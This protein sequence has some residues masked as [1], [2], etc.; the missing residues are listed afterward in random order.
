M[1]PELH[2][3][4]TKAIELAARRRGF[5][6]FME[7]GLGKT[8]TTLHEFNELTKLREAQR[9]VVVCP[10]SFKRGWVADAQ[11][12][13]FD[14]DMYVWEAGAEREC[15]RWFK[16]GFKKPAVLIVNYESIRTEK[17]QEVIR[18][19]I[20]GKLCYLA[21]DESIRLKNNKSLQTKAILGLA[22][23]FEYVRV[24]S[25]KPQTQ[26]P[27][28]LWGQLRAIG[29]IN[30]MSFYAFRTMFCK[31]GGWMN[32][33]VV[34]VQNE[35]HL[36]RLMGD[37]VF[38]ATKHEYAA[39]LPEKTYTIRRYDPNKEVWS[40]YTSMEEEFVTYIN[41][42]EVSVEMAM[43]KYEK[44]AQIQAG[45]ILDTETGALHEIVDPEVNTRIIA[46]QEVM[47][48]VSG[49]VCVV[50]THRH[51]RLLLQQALAAYSPAVIAGG[52]SGD[53]VEAEKA[54]FNN[55]PDC[56]V[57]LL[58]QRSAKYGHTLLGGDNAQDSCSTMVFFEN[59]Y[60]LD[61][62]SQIEDRIHRHG[63]KY[64]CTYID[65]AGT[66]LDFKVVE[67]LQ[68]KESIFQS[69]FRQLRS[70]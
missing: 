27:H 58:Q 54:R 20:D 15:R 47:E 1:L 13:G 48:E 19:F 70:K 22:P 28:D 3:A 14:F 65:L 16:D 42:T 66:E 61:D 59:S 33:Q 51:S 36:G 40:H 23:L 38:Y 68:H 25:G 31:M 64:P 18:S 26:G 30:G 2:I 39:E 11:K 37:S 50:Y 10:N 45:F 43:T 67:A 52:M 56:R 17:V 49:K 34:G 53:D 35:Q 4:Q 21:I 60:S 63:Q 55:D 57:I 12:W 5:A 44:M 69:V 29:L 32:K 7:M 46:I 24:L 41:S 6:F 8:R 9:L 62:R